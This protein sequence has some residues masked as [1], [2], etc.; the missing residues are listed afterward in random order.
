MNAEALTKALGGRWHGSHGVTCCPAH[1]DKSPSFSIRDGDGGNFLTHCFSGCSPEA[2]WAALRD[3]GLVEQFPQVS[4]SGKS[5]GRSRRRVSVAAC[6]TEDRVRGA[7]E[8]WRAARPPASTPVEKYLQHRGITTPVPP[9]LRYH[10]GARYE[11]SGLCLPCMVAAVQGP[12][13]KV[14][15]VHRTYIR[16]DGRGKAGVETPK[17]ALGPIGDGAVRLARAGPVLGLA[18]GIETALSAAQLFGLPVWATL[19][20]SRLG[21]LWLPPEAQEVHVFADN[22]TPGH[23]AAERATKAYQAQGRRVVVRFPPVEFADFSDLLC[24]ED[25][26]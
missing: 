7:L 17:M 16:D 13:R 14:T 11:R 6:E 10:P 20:A 12:D 1:E 22:G 5:S 25:T 4:T 24:A 9:T 2:V 8:I 19:S 15:A 21:R 23:E 26:A 3:R 18:E